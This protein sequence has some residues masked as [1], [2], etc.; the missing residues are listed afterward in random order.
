MTTSY[1]S[2]MSVQLILNLRMFCNISV[3]EKDFRG[4]LPQGE[5]L[6]LSSLLYPFPS[7]HFQKTHLTFG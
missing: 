2:L 6:G 5:T 3:D 1:S 4:L 7:F